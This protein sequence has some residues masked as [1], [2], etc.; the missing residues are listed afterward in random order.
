MAQAAHITAL[1]L[2]TT[3]TDILYLTNCAKILPEMQQI[4][5]K[6]EFSCVLMKI[7]QFSQIMHLL[8]LIGTVVIDTRDFEAEHQQKLTMI[9]ESLEAQ[10]MGTILLKD[11]LHLHVES[12]TLTTVIESLS[13]DRLLDT[14]NSNLERR[15]NSPEILSVPPA[16]I[17]QE[18]ITYTQN[19][20]EQLLMAEAF[21]DNLAEQLRMAGHVQRDFLPS[22]LPK[23]ENLKW[24]TTF[25][26]AEWVSGDIYNIVR[27]DEQH[28]GF[29]LADVVGH[30]IPAALLTIFLKQA[31]VLRETIDNNY[32]ILSPTEVMGNLN[33]RMAEQNLSGYQFA[34]CCYCLLNIKTL[35]LTYSRAGH[36]Y[37]ILIRPNEEI[38]QLEIR[39][40]LL[41]IFEQAQYMQQTVQLQTGDKLL[42]Y[43][44]G[45]E[46]FIGNFDDQKG[47]QFS[48]QFRRI[49]AMSVD[50]M[51]E[52]LNEFA[53]NPQINPAELDDI[54]A[55]VLEII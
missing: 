38:R 39:G 46:S 26:P 22:H 50:Q 52:S 33:L 37:P 55:V 4:L 44:D 35:Q 49:S 19:L 32:R 42:L 11:P 13:E 36:P 16:L 53:R 25:L 54:T 8:D 31:M 23:C 14:I 48:E 6:N 51:M 27:I 28:V 2:P 40:S 30:G 12:F 45:A 20:T 21:V 17:D 47:F 18:D 34:T 7:D 15:R 10:K 1:E 29:Y 41:G 3:F 9:I 24:A 43:S 5:D